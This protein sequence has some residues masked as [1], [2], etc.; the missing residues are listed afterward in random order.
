MDNQKKL[1]QC[2][3]KCEREAA[4]M[5]SKGTGT[6]GGFVKKLDVRGKGMTTIPSA[7]NT[8]NR[9]ELNSTIFYLYIFQ[10]YGSNVIRDA[11]L[12]RKS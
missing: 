2:I 1:E 11:V 3:I 5:E 12:Y 4:Q 10:S 6:N 9:R 8:Q 7:T